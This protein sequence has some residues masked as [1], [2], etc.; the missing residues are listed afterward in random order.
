MAVPASQAL[1]PS[2]AP[3]GSAVFFHAGIREAPVLR[4]DTSVGGDVL[5]VV[6]VI[7][8]GSANYHPRISPD[9]ELVAFDSDRDGE[10]G[11]Y[12][13]S[14]DG[15]GVRRVSG[16]GYAAVPSWSPEGGRL[17]FVR[18]EPGRPRVWNVWILDVPTGRQHRITA[19]AYGQ[20]WGASWL[21]RGNHVVYSHEDRLV[22]H[23]LNTGAERI[24]PSP[25]RGRL[26]RTPAVSPDGRHVI[27]QVYRD[28]A[29]LLELAD[30]SMR[31]VLEDPT[32]E[33]FAWSPDGR[34]VAFH[35]RRAGGWGLWTMSTAGLIQAP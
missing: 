35:S 30:G 5:Q 8:D 34:T 26:A 7:D 19:H 6:R 11:V 29:W 27:F 21:P 31:R 18:A 13:A 9:G 24:F 17:A 20:P 4:A 3:T 2:F 28:G 15:T 33:E 16:E 12:I 22:L 14:R 23:D 10:R 32:A 25:V 1:S